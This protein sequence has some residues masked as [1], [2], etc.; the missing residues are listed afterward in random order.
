MLTAILLTVI[1]SVKTRRRRGKGDRQL[2]LSSQ[3]SESSGGLDKC[4]HQRLDPCDDLSPN[5]RI[6]VIYMPT[7]QSD[8]DN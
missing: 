5:A 8:C 6:G 2:K 7:A 4:S 3:P 1:A